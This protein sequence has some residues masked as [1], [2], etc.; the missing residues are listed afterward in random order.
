MGAIK[1]LVGRVLSAVK[2]DEAKHTR[3]SGACIFAA[4]IGTGKAA[5]Q[6]MGKKGR[7]RAKGSTR[8]HPLVRSKV[9][10]NNQAPP[11]AAMGAVD[12]ATRT[13]QQAPITPTAMNVVTASQ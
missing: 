2:A 12:E 4:V 6:A 7:A 1:R 3:R 10:A 5:A 9:R 11:S 8:R 13:S